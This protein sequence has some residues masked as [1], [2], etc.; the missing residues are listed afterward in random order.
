MSLNKKEFNILDELLNGDLPLSY[1]SQ[2]YRVGER[3]IR[4]SIDNLNFYLNRFSLNK[5]TLKKGVLSWKSSQTTLNSFVEKITVDEYIFSKEERKNYIL[6]NYLFSENTKITDIERYLKV[7]RP[8][9]K[10]D[11]LALNLELKNFDLELIREN[12]SIFIKGKEKKLRHLKLL[13]LL[14]YIEIKNGEL[15][16]ISKLYLT[17]KIESSVIQNY[18]TNFNIVTLYNIVLKI[19]KKLKVTFDTNFKN[20]M[21]IYLIPTLERIEKNRLILKKNNSEFLKTLNDYRLIKDILSEIIPQNLEFEFLHLTEYF[22][23][24]YYSHNFSENLLLVQNFIEEFSKSISVSLS[25]DF[26]TSN[27]YREE[28]LKY[29]LPAVYRIKNNFFLLKKEKT[30][31]NSFDKVIYEKIKIAVLTCNSLLEEPFREEEI[32][33]LTKISQKYIEMENNKEISL[34]KLLNLIKDSCINLNEDKFVSELL[35]I[36]KNKIY[37]DR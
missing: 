29:L 24:G 2:K 8:T 6:I 23:S 36:Y 30:V 5:V 10:K 13:K 18:L 19:E 28:I 1:F 37:D 33:Y 20:L 35:T 27:S 11:I 4:Y 9:I 22:I 26:Y 15:L 16:F 34:T 17:E 25:F 12:N 14:E 21:C 31:M 32:I 3:N 7:S